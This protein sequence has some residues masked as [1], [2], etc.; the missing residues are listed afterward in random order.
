MQ[1]IIQA[2]RI[3]HATLDTPDLQR[4][5][6]YFAFVNG[7]AI[8][9]SD[10][11]AVHLTTNFGQLSVTL[12]QAQRSNCTRL[13]FEVAPDTDFQLVIKELN[14][15]GVA[16]EIR[17]DPFPGSA[18]CLSLTDPNGTGIDLFKS[19]RFLIDNRSIAGVAPLKLG[20]VAMFSPDLEKMVG[21]YEWV[22]GFRVSDW[23]DDFFVFMRCNTDHHTVNFFRAGAAQ[24]HHI[25]FELKD[26][27]HIQHACETL[28]HFKI[29]IGWGPV[30]VPGP[31]H[32][33]AVFHRNPDDHAVEYYCELDQ[34]KSEALGYF[35]P[36]PWHAHK[37]QRPRKWDSEAWLCGWGTP[38]APSFIRPTP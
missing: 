32:N 10:D 5:T 30:R 1:P 28:T 34:M 7:L 27:A 22:L 12:Q 31:G 29:P 25:A 11:Q 19:W 16:S 3:G 23:L 14:R 6:E 38:R 21:F 20:H 15:V 2:Q 36:R 4:A 13:S 26:M 37:P 35:E 18:E 17:S 8:S 24:L 9:E 33:V